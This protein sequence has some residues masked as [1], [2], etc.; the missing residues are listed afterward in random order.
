MKST[1]G[2]K[3][4]TYLLQWLLPIFAADFPLF[5]S[6]RLLDLVVLGGLKCLLQAALAL[7]EAI[8]E[9][10]L[11]MG[12]DEALGFIRGAAA[13]APFAAHPQK[14]RQQ[15]K[16]RQ[17]QQQQIQQQKQK[18]EQQQQ[19][20]P[21]YRQASLSGRNG[22]QEIEMQEKRQQQ[23]SSR[24]MAAESSSSSSSSSLTPSEAW[25]LQR[26]QRFRVTNKMIETLEAAYAERKP[27]KLCIEPGP[28]RGCLRWRVVS[29][30]S[31]CPQMQQQPGR[32]SAV[33]F[34]IVDH[35]FVPASNPT[36]LAPDKKEAP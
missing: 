1:L 26:M 10:L 5:L 30:I 11:S 13:A 27:C 34:C 18:R 16:Q 4:E 22:L 31:C 2:L 36:G 15:R 19:Q 35:Y 14:E 20:Q 21:W 32:H 3:G 9:P 17:Q 8:Q 28:T 6:L 25:L 7:L 23:R 12:L 33:S 24:E 29:D